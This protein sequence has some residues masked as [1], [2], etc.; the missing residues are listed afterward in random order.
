MS[1]QAV[2]AAPAGA[3]IAARLLRAPE[4]SVSLVYLFALRAT[5]L[6]IAAGLGSE[7]WPGILHHDKPWTLMTGVSQS[8]LAALSALAVLGIRYPL[9]MLPLLIFELAWKSIWLLA[10][11]LPA[12]QANRIDQGISETIFACMMGIV[13][14]PIVIPWR[15]VFTTLVRGRG[16]RWW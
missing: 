11:A 1:L 15:Y 14:C 9:R 2:H 7:V 6:L 5:Y 3:G 12:W 10:I 8:L 16:D 13:I 4:G